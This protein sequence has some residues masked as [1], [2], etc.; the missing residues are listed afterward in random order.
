MIEFKIDIKATSASFVYFKL[1]DELKSENNYREFNYVL[2]KGYEIDLLNHKHG[3]KP[4]LAIDSSKRR[5]LFMRTKLPYFGYIFLS[6]LLFLF[7][8]FVC[9]YLY[10]SKFNPITW[11]E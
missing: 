2:F 3:I 7:I 10:F 4:K 1:L 8:N 5:H 9:Y 6:S 11:K